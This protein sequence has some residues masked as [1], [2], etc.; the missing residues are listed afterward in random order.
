MDIRLCDSSPVCV[1]NEIIDRVCRASAH[2]GS[3]ELSMHFIFF[4]FREE[5][6]GRGGSLAAHLKDAFPSVFV[7]SPS[8]APQ[9]L[10]SM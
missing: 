8:E 7:S 6:E 2:P 9:G 5:R 4:L 3:K 1:G 10:V